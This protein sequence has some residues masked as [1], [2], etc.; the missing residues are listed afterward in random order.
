MK[1]KR[2]VQNF[3]F[4]SSFSVSFKKKFDTSEILKFIFFFFKLKSYQK[5][6]FHLLDEEESSAFQYS[7]PRKQMLGC[8]KDV[9]NKMKPVL[10]DFFM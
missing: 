10:Y 8:W 9:V 5:T 3:H 1:T 6:K 7:T 2:E 4:Y